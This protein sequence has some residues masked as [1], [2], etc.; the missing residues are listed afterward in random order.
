MKMHAE[1]VLHLGKSAE[2][3][4]ITINLPDGAGQSRLY[5]QKRKILLK[6]LR[7]FKY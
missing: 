5:L 1:I 4:S 6:P 2:S 7:G 3:I